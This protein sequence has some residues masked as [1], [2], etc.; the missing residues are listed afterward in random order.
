MREP[1]GRRERRVRWVFRFETS[2]TCGRWVRRR[3]DRRGELYIFHVQIGRPVV[4][5]ERG[6]RTDL[7]NRD[8]VQGSWHYVEKRED[9]QPREER[10]LRGT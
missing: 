4:V 6:N 3:E 5:K 8:G 1:A 2:A 10:S 9:V 7:D